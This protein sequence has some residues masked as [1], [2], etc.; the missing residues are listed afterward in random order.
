MGRKGLW[1]EQV[2]GLRGFLLF[3]QHHSVGV[4]VVETLVAD[5]EEISRGLLGACS[6]TT[7]VLKSSPILKLNSI[8]ILK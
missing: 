7:D 2:G 1:R 6:E 5:W 8:K 3:P 4:W